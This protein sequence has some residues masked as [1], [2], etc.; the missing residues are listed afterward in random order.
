MQGRSHAGSARDGSDP[1]QVMSLKLCRSVFAAVS[2]HA[3]QVQKQPSQYVRLV[4]EREIAQPPRTLQSGYAIDDYVTVPFRVRTSTVEAVRSRATAAGLKPSQLIR[5]V[6]ED[7]V[8]RASQ[9]NP[10]DM[11]RAG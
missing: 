5:A 7:H 9:T 2:R 10:P 3:R 11:R 1:Y 6:L 8:L 4:I